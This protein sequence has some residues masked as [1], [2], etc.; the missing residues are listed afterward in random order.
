MLRRGVGAILGLSPEEADACHCASPLRFRIFQEV[1]RRS[2]DPDVFVGRWLEQG[3]PVGIRVPIDPGG[4]RPLIHEERSLSPTSLEN[5]PQFESNHD[6]F[7]LEDH[8]KLPAHDLLRDL[9]DQGFATLRTDQQ[10]AGEHLGAEVVVSPLGDVTKPKPA[11]PLG[12][13][14][15]KTSARLG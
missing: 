7:D 11:V 14:S 15:F 13:A 3:A 1:I 4:L 6:T 8:G 9:V 2:G 12:T 5:L 10:A